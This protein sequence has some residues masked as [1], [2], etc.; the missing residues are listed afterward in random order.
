MARK[1]ESVTEA[2]HTENAPSESSDALNKLKVPGAK[3][4]GD[5]ALKLFQHHNVNDPV[6]LNEEK[7]LVRKIDLIILPLIAVNYAF[8]YID[9]TTLSYAA[10]F[11]IREDL[12]LHGTQYSWLSS[13]WMHND[14]AMFNH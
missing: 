7:R 12:K 11:G 8:F 2:V 5:V 6:D 13:K 1:S 10:I 14:N 4:D 9:K 3:I